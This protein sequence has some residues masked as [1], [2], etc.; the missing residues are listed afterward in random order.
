MKSRGLRTKLF[1]IAIAVGLCITGALFALEYYSY[2]GALNVDGEHS[3]RSLL[4]VEAQRLELQAADLATEV[5]PT[6]EAAIR[7][8]DTAAIR[9]AGEYLLTNPVV[10]AATVTDA[11]GRPLFAGVRDEAWVRTLAPEERRT[12]KRDLGG[13]DALGTIQIETGRAGLLASAR[14]LRQSID[15]SQ[16]RNW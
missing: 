9:R 4:E 15:R 2:R 12:V 11:K 13:I 1:G 5:T 10:V 3:E 14:A 7:N 16:E 6:L 8:S